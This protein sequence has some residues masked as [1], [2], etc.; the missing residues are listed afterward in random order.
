M[1][2]EAKMFCNICG[3]EIAIEEMMEIPVNNGA[4]DLTHLRTCNECGKKTLDEQREAM[5]R[6]YLKDCRPFTPDEAL[7]N[8]PGKEVRTAGDTVR[9]IITAVNGGKV[10]AGD[11]WVTLEELLADYWF[12]YNTPCGERVKK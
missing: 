3:K 10:L 9:C 11:H 6:A 2:E 7:K 4:F 12:S 5:R 8:L 1:S